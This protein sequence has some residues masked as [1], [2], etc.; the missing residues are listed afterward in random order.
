MAPEL[1]QFEDD[2]ILKLSTENVTPNCASDI[3]ALGITIWEMITGQ[4]SAQPLQPD[5]LI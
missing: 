3:Y 5:V 4:V 1:L 2:K